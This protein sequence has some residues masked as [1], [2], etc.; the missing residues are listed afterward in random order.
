MPFGTGWISWRAI[1]R[2]QA[3]GTLVIDDAPFDVG[4]LDCYYDHNWGRWH[5]GD[6]VGWEYGAFLAPEPGP[7]FLLSRPTDRAHRTG[8]PRL[9]V[10][11]D[12]RERRFSGSTVRLERRGR[13]G[14]YVHRTPGAM[15]ALRIDRRAPSMP[16]RV[17]LQF[18]DGFIDGHLALSVD[19]VAQ[20]ICGEPAERGTSFIHELCGR[21]SWELTLEAR[22][23]LDDDVVL[24]RF[25]ADGALVTSDD[26][27]LATIY[28]EG[29]TT[30]AVV[31]AVIEGRLDATDA[32]TSGLVDVRGRPD[33]VVAMLHMVE[34]L[35]DASA[36]LPALRALADEFVAQ[37]GVDGDHAPLFDG[38]VAETDV[39]RRLGLLPEEP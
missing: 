3:E 24:V 7:A 37:A 16:A 10:H 18:D 35:L 19:A 23:A 38:P 1:P 27:T 13:W 31:V 22:L 5:W 15:A 14:G 11:V 34:L 17:E 4:A 30:S 8:L 20:I 12:D 25:D 6:D 32:V 29:A 2:L 9:T 36:R 39:L 28:G 33:T 21:F 26:S